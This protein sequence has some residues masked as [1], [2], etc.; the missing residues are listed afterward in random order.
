MATQAKKKSTAKKSPA[1]GR[2]KAAPAR[3]KKARAQSAAQ[4]S[5]DIVKLILED[6]KPLKRL[7]ETL[8]DT[9]ESFAKRQ[10]AFEEFGARLIAHAKPEEQALYVYMKEGNELRTEGFEGDVEHMIADQLLQEAQATNDEDL[11]SA[12]VKVLAELVEHHIE[13]EEEEMLPEF[14]KEATDEERSMIGQKYLHLKSKYDTWTGKGEPAP[15]TA[16]IRAQH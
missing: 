8:K 14:K 16:D 7:I 13:E 15:R 11:W 12:Q 6:H 10:A 5:D 3:A 4:A 9:E 1:K 2:A